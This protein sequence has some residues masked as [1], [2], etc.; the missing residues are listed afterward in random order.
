MNIFIGE[1]VSSQ[2]SGASDMLDK[3][4][5][6]AIQ[7]LG[8]AKTFKA[9]VVDHP[10]LDLPKTHPTDWTLGPD[11]EI[12]WDGIV[13]ESVK[14]LLRLFVVVRD[15]MTLGQ[16]APVASGLN[17]LDA[18]R[19]DAI[20]EKAEKFLTDYVANATP[21]DLPETSPPPGQAE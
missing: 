8:A 2:S 14:M 6:R 5:A 1:L 13:N 11:P 15:E 20:I 10:Q 17:D 7:Y 4:Q 21:Q 16:S 12:A 9:W 19:F 3:D 18:V